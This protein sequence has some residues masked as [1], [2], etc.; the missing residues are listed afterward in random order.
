[1]IWFKLY[2]NPADTNGMGAFTGGTAMPQVQEELDLE[3]L[4][5]CAYSALDDAL[6]EAGVSCLNGK[7]I[8]RRGASP[9]RHLDA[10][11]LV[12][13][14]WVGAGEGLALPRAERLSYWSCPSAPVWQG[15]KEGSF[16]RP[17]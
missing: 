14:G 6:R 3:Q 5:I 11:N 10:V 1:M 8:P 7:L 4:V 2:E 16:L 17:W 12:A 9:E 15:V 13:A